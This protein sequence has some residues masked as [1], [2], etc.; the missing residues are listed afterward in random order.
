MNIV[1]PIHLTGGIILPG[2]EL[3]NKISAFVSSVPVATNV[4]SSP[5]V[6]RLRKVSDSIRS[7][8]ATPAYI[9]SWLLA[10]FS[11]NFMPE[12]I[13]KYA[14]LK[15][16]CKSV[17]V[18]SNV[19]GPPFKIHWNGKLVSDIV[20]F[21]PLPPGV[22]IGVL[23]RSY[24]GQMMISLNADKRIVP[25]ADKFTDWILEEYEKLHREVAKLKCQ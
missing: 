16:N 11:I 6:N 13:T 24:A 2:T 14:M 4:S 18:I 25:D 7:N 22:P 21:V 17:A 15:C 23:V 19:K 20:P 10:K 3:G 12:A 5:S 9:I 1:I 8:K